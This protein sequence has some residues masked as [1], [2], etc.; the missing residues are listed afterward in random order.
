MHVKIA[1]KCPYL[2]KFNIHLY[3]EVKNKRP[4]KTLV[5]L[6]DKGAHFV[7]ISNTRLE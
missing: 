6:R 7:T 5:C 1:Q 2:E 4:I 3:R